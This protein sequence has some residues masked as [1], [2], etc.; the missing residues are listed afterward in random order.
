[1]LGALSLFVGA[2]IAAV[3]AAYGG[4]Q[5]DDEEEVYLQS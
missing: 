4:R 1:L 5:R 3:A 2:F